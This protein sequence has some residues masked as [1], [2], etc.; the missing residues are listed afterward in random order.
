MSTRGAKPEQPRAEAHAFTGALSLYER[1][2]IREVVLVHQ[3]SEVIFD[4]VDGG[5]PMLQR[6]FERR[7]RGYHAIGYDHGEAPLGYTGIDDGRVVEL[8]LDEKVDSDES[9]T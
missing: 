7:L 3:S 9:W 1:P 6:M 8:D 4:Y 2:G 5:V